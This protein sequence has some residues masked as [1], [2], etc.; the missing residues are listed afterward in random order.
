MF[1]SDTIQS[2]TD[3]QQGPLP[4]P[5]TLDRLFL[6]L[7]IFHWLR[8]SSTQTASYQ[9]MLLDVEQITAWMFSRSLQF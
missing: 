1:R 3:S 5:G 8:G 4:M 2:S 6:I 9:E 7:F